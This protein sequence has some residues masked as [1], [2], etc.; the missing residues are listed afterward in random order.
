MPLAV[1]SKTWRLKLR[2]I[3]L[4]VSGAVLV[5]PA[6][7]IYFLKLY[8]NELVR[9]TELELISQAALIAALYKR[10]I[11]KLTAGESRQVPAVLL[12]CSL[13]K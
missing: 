2:T 6:G 7:G 8:E 9:Q 11:E 5:L 1:A 3:L 4:A 10:E 12:E 13:L